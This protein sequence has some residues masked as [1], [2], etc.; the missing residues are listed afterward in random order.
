MV[1]KNKPAIPARVLDK[2]Q[3]IVDLLAQI[4]HVPAGLVMELDGNSLKVCVASASESNPYE[5]GETAEINT[6]LYCETVMANQSELL[7]RNAL[8]DEAWRANPDV[9]KNMLFYLGLPLTWPDGEL[10]GT[11]C[12]LDTD[13]NEKAIQYRALLEEFRGI[14]DSDLRYLVDLAEREIMELALRTA[15]DKLEQRVKERTRELS[16]TNTALKILL[17]KREQDRID[18]EDRVLA[19]VNDRIMPHIRKLKKLSR[20]ERER[21]YLE[22]LEAN[23]S[24][25]VSPFS[26]FLAT[27]CKSLTP[28]EME[29]TSLIKQGRKTKE[30]AHMMNLSTSTIDFHRNNIRKKLGIA[31]HKTNLRTYLASMS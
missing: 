9:E 5:H 6:G 25:I 18:L 17:E 30:I 26:N 8:Q 2:W 20:D 1:S 13:N 14:T 22:V 7:V 28:T 15:Y 29:V 24:D 27:R 10:F 12:V 11:I 3:R 16:E 4:L 23:V 31:N 19:N 21:S